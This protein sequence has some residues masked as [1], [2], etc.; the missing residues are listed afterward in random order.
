MDQAD[1]ARDPDEQMRL[2]ELYGRMM[3]T[4]Q[5]LEEQRSKLREMREE[6]VTFIDATAP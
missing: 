3:T 1:G 2:E 6:L 5:G 4:A